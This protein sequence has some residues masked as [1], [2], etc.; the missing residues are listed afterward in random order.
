M[1]RRTYNAAGEV[2][3]HVNGDGEVHSFIYDEVSR[4][5]GTTDPEGYAKSFAYDVRDNVTSVIDGRGGQTIFTYDVLNRMTGRTNPL[6]LSMGREYDSR[7]NLIVLIR[8]DGLSETASYDGLGRRIAVET[9]DNSLS[10]T[11]DPVGNLISAQDN[12]SRVTFAWDNRNRLLSTTTDGTFG[13]QPEVTLTYTYDALDRRTSMSDSLG[14]TTAYDWDVESRLATLTA[15]WGT[16][17]TFGYDGD[18]RRTSL[19]SSTGRVTTYGYTNSLLTAL[20]HAQAGVTLTDLSYAY[21]EDGQLTAIIDNLDPAR[22]EVYAYDALNRL[23]QVAQ[24]LPVSQGGAPIPV[25]DYAYDQEG[26]RTASHLSVTH[27]SSDHN[28]IL[29]DD[30]YTYGYDDRGNRIERIS[31]ATGDIESYVYDS[32]NRL[33]GYSSP[34]TEASYAYDALDRRIAKVVDGVTEAFVYDAWG[35]ASTSNEV[36]LDFTDG[37]LTRRWLHGPEVD[38][39][40]AF[41]DIAGA[42]GTAYD[43]HADRQGSILRVVDPATGTVAAEYAYDSFG[44]RVA[45]GTLDQRY[46]FTGR[47]ADGE[48]GLLYFRARHYDPLTGMFL[49]RDPIGFAAGDLNLYAY[50]WNNPTKWSDPSGLNATIDYGAN[51]LCSGAAAGAAYGGLFGAIR[52]LAMR[53]ARELT[54]SAMSGAPDDAGAGA[55]AGAGSGAGPNEPGCEPNDPKCDDDGEIKDRLENSDYNEAE[56]YL[57]EQLRD[58]RGWEKKPLNSKYPDQG[59]R[60]FDGRGNSVQI[61]KGYGT[62]FTGSSVKSG[63]YAKISSNG[64]VSRFALK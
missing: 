47:E 41:L 18:G 9:P 26:N 8:E 7:N 14:G 23:L 48:S 24:G 46:A 13:L 1:I 63:P 5:T 31:K 51:G 28:Q 20:S 16:D 10:Y 19:T 33:I 29:E 57:D 55:G 44:N 40:L 62:N 25:E 6:G 30:S 50:T 37:A 39:P 15:P 38:E 3:G 60:Y 58:K 11:F 27:V 54:V 49:Q 32:Q 43:L 42:G 36:V 21:G 59:V 61:N 53:I 34:T 12:D 17:W 64:T 22:S 35:M 2:T 52:N 4:L 56:N 45:T